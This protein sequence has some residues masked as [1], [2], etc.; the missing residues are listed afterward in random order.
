MYDDHLTARGIAH[1]INGL[2]ARAMLATEQLRHHQDERV[3]AHAG[4]ICTAIDRVAE[5]CRRELA[6]QPCR[7]ATL[8]LSAPRVERIVQE[9]ANVVAA[10]S[11]LGQQPIEFFISVADDVR[12]RTD[13]QALFRILFNLAL[14]AANA[15]ARHGGTWIELSVAQARGQVQFDVIDDGPG[16]PDHVLDYL[17]PSLGTRPAARRGRIGSG[18]I[19]AVSLASDLEGELTLL[20][21][22]SAGTRFRLSLP[23]LSMTARRGDIVIPMPQAAPTLCDAVAGA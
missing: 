2:M 8:Y 5:I 6:P 10:E 7:G 18:L 14:N 9:V 23:G 12:L 11:V 16:L 17:Y 22:N 3:V 20:Q 1:D 4:R 21:S 15:L 13:P 19:T